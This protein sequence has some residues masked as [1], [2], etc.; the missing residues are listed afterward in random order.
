MNQMRMTA[1]LFE[2]DK[3]FVELKRPVK[4]IYF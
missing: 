2:D 1:L 4:N 3:T